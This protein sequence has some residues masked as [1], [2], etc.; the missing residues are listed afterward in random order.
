[1][2]LVPQT[3]VGLAAALLVSVAVVPAVVVEIVLTFVVPILAVGGLGL[4]ELAAVA[5]ERAA[6]VLWN[7]CSGDTSP[8]TRITTIAGTRPGS[9]GGASSGTRSYFVLHK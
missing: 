2:S 9:G 5:A 8:S 4:V 6:V 7:T 1:M 3:T